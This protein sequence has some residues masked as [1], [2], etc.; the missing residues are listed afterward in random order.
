MIVPRSSGSLRSS[1]RRSNGIVIRE[2]GKPLSRQES[3]EGKGKNVI[4]DELD[5][6]VDTIVEDLHGLMNVE[7]SASQN[8]VLRVRNFFEVYDAQK[9][10]NMGDGA[11][12]L[13]TRK[14][15]IVKNKGEVAEAWSKPKPIKITFDRDLMEFSEDGVA[16]K[17]NAEREAENVRVLKNSIVLKVLGNRVPFSVCSSE[18]RRQWSQYGKFHLTSIGLDWILYSFNLCEVV[19][20]VL[21]GGP[22]YVNGLI[23]GMD[24]WTPAFDPNSFKDGNTFRWSKREFARV[25]VR[26]DLEKKLLNGAWVEGSAGRFFQRVEYEKIDL[27]CYQCGRVGHDKKTCPENVTLVIK[28]QSLKSIGSDNGQDNLVRHDNKHSVKDV[29]LEEVQEK[30]QDECN[31]NKADEVSGKDAVTGMFEQ[32][33][34]RFAVLEENE[35]ELLGKAVSNDKVVDKGSE[36]LEPE[37]NLDMN[38]GSE[39]VKVKLAKELKSLGPVNSEKKKRNGRGARKKE[40]SMYLKEMVRDENVFF[41]GLME[42]KLSSI[43]RMEVDCLM[44]NEWDYFYQPA[45]GTSGGILVLWNIK[46]VSFE[47]CEASSQVIIGNL[48][49]PSLGI[50]KIATVYGSRCSKKRSDLWNQLERSMENS[51]PSIIGGD[52]NCILNKDEKRGGKRFL[53]SKGPREMKSFM[54]NSD[55]HD[56]GYVGPRFTWCNNKEGNSRIWERLDRCILNSLAMQKLPL[57]VNRHLARMASDHCLVVIKMDDRIRL[58]TKTIKFEDTWRSYPAAKSIVNKCKDLNALKDKLKKEILDLQN[59]EALSSNWSAN[60]L[61]ELRNKVNQLNITMRRLSTWWNQRAK[62][63]WHEEGNTNSKLFHNFATARRNGNRIF[64]VKDEA[65]KLQV[66]EDQIEKVFTKFFEKKWEYRECEVT[67][68]PSIMENQKLNAEDMELLNAEF[69]KNELQIAMFQ[70]GNNKSPGVDGVTSSFYKSYWNIIWETLWNAVRNFFNSSHMNKEWKDTLIVLIPKIK[71]PLSSSNYRPI[72]LCQINYKIVATMLVNRLKKGMARM[73]SE[74]QAAFIHGRSIAEHCLLAQEI[75]HK[76]KISK[77]K[78]GMMAVKLDMEQAYDSMGW[79]TLRHILRWY[80]FPIAFSNLLLECVVDVRFFIIINWKNSEWINAQSGFRQGCP[81]SPYLFI[82]CFQM[83]TNSL[84]QRGKNLGIQVSSGGPKIT[85]LLYADDALIFSHASVELAKSMRTI[86]EKFCKWT[87][88][89]INIGKSQLLFGKVVNYHMRRKIGR[90][91]GFKIVKEMR[92]LGVKISL[93]IMKMADYQEVLSNAMERLNAWSR[94]SLSLGGKLI[95]VESS[96][97]SMV[98]FLITQSLVPKRLLHDLEKLCRS[99]IWNNKDGTKGMHYIAWNDICKPSSMGGLGLHSP[100]QRIGSLRSKVT[101]NFIQKPGSLLHRVMESKYGDNVMNGANRNISSNAWKILLDGG[102]NLKMVVRWKVGKGDKISILN[103]TWVLD[104]CINRW[105]TFVDS[106]FLDGMSVQQLILDNGMSNYELL[107]RAFHPYLISL[108]TQI[109]IEYNEEDQMELMKIGSGKTVSAM[110][111]EQ[112]W[113]NKCN[114]EDVEYFSW[115]KKLKMSKNIEMFWWRLGK[116]AIPTNM[117]LMNCKIS[118]NGLCPRG[119]QV[120]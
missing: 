55:F 38:Y 50:W 76:F 26:I 4:M 120:D 62:A 68:W 17:L 70:Q 1:D 115:V 101:W 23:V 5:A 27:M 72:S 33:T 107:Q 42:T 51:S 52:F 118:D 7:S 31:D 111:F 29:Q 49:I 54:V 34:N 80:G 59:K 58:K 24:R 10:C 108:I 48:S 110:V 93:E 106:N 84:E 105:P 61:F 16:V 79:T 2:G 78:K 88:Q 100:L 85:H 41:I 3:V 87:G 19:D 102:K 15:D 71:S 9:V 43:G 18:L 81:L 6:R 25:F 57:V 74:E 90:L 46:L 36:L 83:I 28:D 73:I 92:Y 56:I 44:G 11:V 103:D 86:M 104:K 95:L 30:V 98:N 94:K 13:E 116:S 8:L 114:M 119:C 77:N 89:R 96:L 66:E 53:F 45:V 113:L 22:W 39:D 37:V 40:A 65:N 99:F 32:S 63:R 67:G 82:M 60:D 117:F 97:L 75:F 64:Q 21:N 112:M 69:T 47:V 91:L 35:E 109:P 20:E 12:S 14:E